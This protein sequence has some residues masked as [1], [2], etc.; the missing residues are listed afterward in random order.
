MSKTKFKK[1]Y[2]NIALEKTINFFKKSLNKKE[3]SNI[4][5]TVIEILGENDYNTRNKIIFFLNG[6]IKWYS[7]NYERLPNDKFKKVYVDYVFYLWKEKLDDKISLLPVEPGCY[8]KL[9]Q[10]KTHI[11]NM[12]V[13]LFRSERYRLFNE[14]K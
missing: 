1:E 6:F 3:H 8:G 2:D 11:I 4:C 9:R 14:H 13:A 10:I 5:D 12:F 7:E